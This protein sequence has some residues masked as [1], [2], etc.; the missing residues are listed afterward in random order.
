MTGKKENQRGENKFPQK[1]Q[2]GWYWDGSNPKL[3][4]PLVAADSFPFL[5]W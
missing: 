1:I 3:S 5:K 2:E 4:R